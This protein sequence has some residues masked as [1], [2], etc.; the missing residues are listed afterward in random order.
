ME[1][2]EFPEKTT[3]HSRIYMQSVFIAINICDS[4]HTRRVSFSHLK[5]K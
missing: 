5:S 3:D 1:E 4:G 2:L